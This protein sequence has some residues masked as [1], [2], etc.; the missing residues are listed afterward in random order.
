MGAAQRVEG[1]AVDETLPEED[2]VLDR[3]A[4]YV[5]TWGTSVVLHVAVMVLAAFFTWQSV[6]SQPTPV[7]VGGYVRLKPPP[8]VESRDPP[9][10][11]PEARTEE[12]S[13]RW[14]PT[15]VDFGSALDVPEAPVLVSQEVVISA[16]DTAGPRQP[17]FRG[18]DPDSFSRRRRIFEEE[19]RDG[20]PARKIV[21]V[22][23]RSGSMTDGLGLVKLELA[24]AI[25]ELPEDKEFHIIFYSSGPPLE[26]PTRRLVNATERN[27]RLAQ[28]FIDGVIAQGETDPSEALTR[29][30]AVRPDA[31]YLL[32]DGEF[33]KAVVDLVKRLNANRQVAVHTIGFLYTPPGS[34]AEAILKEI[35]DQ[36]GGQYRFV[37]ER[38][39]ATLDP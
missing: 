5:P 12:H 28:E 30:L 6:A 29:A 9:P 1:R 20:E 27:K 25:G 15:R 38:D 22:V 11:R 16:W 32:T 26:M 4:L 13:D 37:S 35:A 7:V 24:Q 10:K 34:A 31:V 8:E 3:L 2:T 21:Y 19:V 36:S 23:D 17:L 18:G 33:D 14:A 39:L